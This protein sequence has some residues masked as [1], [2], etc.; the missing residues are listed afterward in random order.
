MYSWLPLKRE[1]LWPDSEA[2]KGYADKSWPELIEMISQ[3]TGLY[4]TKFREMG[5]AAPDSERE[6]AHSMVVHESAVDTLC[7][8]RASR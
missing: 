1:T 5:A 8:A 2:S 7:K 3:V 6:L 4:S